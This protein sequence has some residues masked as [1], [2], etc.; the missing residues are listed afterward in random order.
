LAKE[1]GRWGKIDNLLS[2]GGKFLPK[3]LSLSSEKYPEKTY[4]GSRVKKAPDPDPDPQHC[5]GP[6]AGCGYLRGSTVT[7]GETAT[8]FPS[9]LAVSSGGMG[10]A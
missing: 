8:L 6:N 3:N 9:S 2:K 10:W 5:T 7:M 1:F 4:S